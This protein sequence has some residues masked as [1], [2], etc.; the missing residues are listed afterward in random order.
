M[1][2]PKRPDGLNTLLLRNDLMHLHMV[3]HCIQ[4][5]RLRLI[6]TTVP[7]TTFISQYYTDGTMILLH[8]SQDI[9]GDV[10]NVCCQYWVYPSHV[11]I[12]TQH[13]NTI[14]CHLPNLLKDDLHPCMEKVP[15]FFTMFSGTG[16]P[17]ELD[18]W[19]V[20]NLN[21]CLLAWLPAHLLADIPDQ[22]YT[23]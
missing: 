13:L 18:N 19:K 10:S 11:P 8:T 3:V 6:H 14:P 2:S 22:T 21:H 12:C 7:T 15:A 4:H 16:L 17:G 20:H 1:V 9:A 23:G 5:P